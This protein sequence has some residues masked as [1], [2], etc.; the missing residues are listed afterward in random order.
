MTGMR[1]GEVCGLRWSEL[2]LDA[3]RMAVVRSLNCIEGR[4]VFAKHPKSDHGR[5][6]IDLDPETVR[7]LREHRRQQLERCLAGGVG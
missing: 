1:R 4:L 2:D 3:G 6:N 5:P 7:T